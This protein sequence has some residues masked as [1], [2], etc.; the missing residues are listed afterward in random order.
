[1]VGTTKQKLWDGA[2]TELGHRNVSTSEN[3]PPR[4][5]LDLVYDKV[6]EECLS[7]ASWNFAMKSQQL[8]SD[9]GVTVNFG[10][11]R[12]FAKPSDWLRTF[13]LSADEEFSIPLTGY[14][15]EKSRIIADATPIYAQFVSN[16]TGAG[17]DLNKWPIKFTRYVECELADRTC[18]RLTGDK[19][20]KE[21]IEGRTH[22]EKRE[23][24]AADAMD[25]SIKFRPMSSWAS[26]RLSQQRSRWDR[27]KRDT[28]IG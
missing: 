26:A 8:D 21:D 7:E 22:R 15:D 12:I 25:E 11:Q 5:T 3:G 18:M 28:L 17:L 2:M 16:D 19:K 24:K 6:V 27:G 1:M 9:T 20:L 10:Q 13:A 23:A 4:R 14:L